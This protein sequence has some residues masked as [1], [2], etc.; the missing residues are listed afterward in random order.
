MLLSKS[1]AL[2]SLDMFVLVA[3]IHDVRELMNFCLLL[4]HT[5]PNI[6]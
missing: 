2:Y 6:S 5:E 4:A 3:N 1:L